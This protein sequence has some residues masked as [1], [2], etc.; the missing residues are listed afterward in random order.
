VAFATGYV[1][2]REKGLDKE[3]AYR[4][5]PFE[6]EAVA[7]EKALLKTLSNK[8]ML[9][10]FVDLL[11]RYDDKQARFSSSITTTDKAAKTLFDE[12]MNEMGAFPDVLKSMDKRPVIVDRWNQS[13]L[14]Q[15]EITILGPFVGPPA[16]K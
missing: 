7:V 12:F 14:K 3:A 1:K 8:A 5:I 4:N 9:D 13:G 16:P 15:R 10:L 6:R 2:N 11:N